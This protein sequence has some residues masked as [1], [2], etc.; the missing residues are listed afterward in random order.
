MQSV[1]FSE[2]LLGT[3][4]MPVVLHTEMSCLPCA[5]YVKV[6]LCISHKE[7]HT[8]SLPQPEQSILGMDHSVGGG[9]L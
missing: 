7:I 4:R 2:I 3:K 9:A 1:N 8:S 5:C 6:Q